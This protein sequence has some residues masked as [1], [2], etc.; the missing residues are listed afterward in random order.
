MSTYVTRYVSHDWDTCLML[1]N[2]VYITI[3]KEFLL[4]Y[5]NETFGEAVQV[6]LSMVCS[7]FRLF[8]F[9]FSRSR[10]C[11]RRLCDV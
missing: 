6:C 5:F 3:T 8:R 7:F 1:F 11:K 10:H 9:V 4:D 2:K